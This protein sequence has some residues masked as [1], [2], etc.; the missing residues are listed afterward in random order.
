MSCLALKVIR[1]IGLV[2]KREVFSSIVGLLVSR[3]TKSFSVVR[4]QRRLSMIGSGSGV[5]NGSLVEEKQKGAQKERENLIYPFING[6]YGQLQY[7]SGERYS[8][9]ARLEPI[10]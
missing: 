9:L 10:F 3:K 2:N 7:F 8:W 4:E 1:V 6:S 5:F